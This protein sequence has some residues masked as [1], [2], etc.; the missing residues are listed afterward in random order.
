MRKILEAA[1]LGAIIA[2]TVTLAMYGWYDFFESSRDRPPHELRDAVVGGSCLLGAFVF[3]KALFSRANWK[4]VAEKTVTAATISAHV[5]SKQSAKIRDRLNESTEQEL[6]FY[7]S[8]ADEVANN[9]V[10]AGLWA[11][12]FSDAD[13][14]DKKQQ[15][16]YIKSRAKALAKGES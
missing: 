5:A 2:G 11:K 3:L 14:D 4:G 8:A 16:L 6:G 15:A 10:H 9:T 1:V 12:A 13:G 7:A